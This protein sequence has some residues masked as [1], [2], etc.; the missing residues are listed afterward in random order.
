MAIDAEEPLAL[1][2]LFHTR[3]RNVVIPM[4]HPN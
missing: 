2:D 1:N 3:I 4:S